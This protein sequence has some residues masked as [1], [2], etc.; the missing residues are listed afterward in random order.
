[1]LVVVADAYIPLLALLLLYY[2]YVEY[3]SFFNKQLIFLGILLCVVY[4]LMLLDNT[5]SLWSRVGLDYSTH[6]A[7]SCA[8]VVCVYSIKPKLL[9][10]LSGSLLMYFWLMIYLQ[11]HTVLDI[12]STISVIIFCYAA[13]TFLQKKQLF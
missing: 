4:G 9:Y 11:Y 13:V 8:L 6:S 2:L 3:K 7:L 1:M 5:Y 12:L 10:T